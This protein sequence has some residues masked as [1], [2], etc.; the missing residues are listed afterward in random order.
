MK[1]HIKS[2]ILILTS[3]I[4]LASFVL[5]IFA[6]V[7]VETIVPPP[8]VSINSS[9]DLNISKSTSY[10]SNKTINI[11]QYLIEDKSASK[12][13][14]KGFKDIKNYDKHV[15]SA[16]D[17]LFD[18][19][20]SDPKNADWNAF[21]FELAFTALKI[22][23]S[24]CGA[25]EITS[26]IVDGI[27]SLGAS[28]SETEASLFL[29]EIKSEFSKIEEDI[30]LARE[31]ISELSQQTDEQTQQLISA[32]YVA[33]ESQAAQQ[34]LANFFSSTDGNFNYSQL[35]NYL[36]GSTN[37]ATNPKYTQAYANKLNESKA[38]AGSEAEKYYYDALFF[39]LMATDNGDSCVNMFFDSILPQ[40][41]AQKSIIYYYYEY[42]SANPDLLNGQSAEYLT[43]KFAKDLYETAYELNRALNYCYKY[44]ELYL[45]REYGNN[46]SGDCLY[47]YGDNSKTNVITYTDIMQ[48]LSFGLDTSLESLEKQ[49]VFDLSNI[50]SM[51]DSYTIQDGDSY[52]LVSN[53]NAST[54]GN[55]LS[56]QTVYLN[57]M[58]PALIT[59][60]DLDHTGFSY[61]FTTN[62]ALDKNIGP[63]YTVPSNLSNFL[64]TL[65]YKGTTL[66]TIAFDVNVVNSFAGGS[67]TK[68]DPYLISNANQLLMLFNNKEHLDK[69]FIIIKD[70]NLDGASINMLGDHNN[71]FRGSLDGN[72]H[73]ISN[74][75]ING[76]SNAALFYGIDFGATVQNLKIADAE[77]IVNNDCQSEQ[78]SHAAAITIINGGKIFNCHVSKSSVSV[79]Q[80]TTY[81]NKSISAYAG[82]I[83]SEN[84][85]TIDFSSVDEVNVSASSTRNYGTN[86]DDSNSSFCYAGGIAAFTD[87]YSSI[88]NCYTKVNVTSY[89]KSSGHG[90]LRTVTPTISV[91]SGGLVG[92]IIGNPKITNVF[93]D[94]TSSI[95]AEYK[96][97][98]TTYLAGWCSDD[99]CE[100]HKDKY[101]ASDIECTKASDKEA[102][103]YKADES[104]I[105]V[106]YSFS[107]NDGKTNTTFN[108]YEGLV[109]DH[110]EKLKLDDLILDVNGEKNVN[111]TI[112]S[113]IYD[114]KNSDKSNAKETIATLIVVA[115]ISTGPVVFDLDLPIVINKNVPVELIIDTLPSKYAYAQ[116]DSIDLTGGSFLLNYKD[117]SSVNVTRN[118]KIVSENPTENLGKNT[119]TVQFDGFSVSFDI[120]VFCKSYIN[121]G[122]HNLYTEEHT[123]VIEPN[124]TSM[125]YTVSKCSDCEYQ[126]TYKYTE[127]L[128]HNLS[129]ENYKDPTCTSTGYSGDQVC[130]R[131][132][133]T[134]EQGNELKFINHVYENTNNATAH[135]CSVCGT[136]EEHSFST[137]ENE[138]AM[139][140]T[141]V[142]CD[143]AFTE[144]KVLSDDTPRVVVSHAYALQDNNGLITVYVQMINNPGITGASFSVNYDERLE[145]VEYYA[146]DVLDSITSCKKH[147]DR[148]SFY[149]TMAK[150]QVEKRDGN[151]LKL[152]FRM[153]EHSVVLDEYDISISFSRSG[154]QF[155]DENN[156]PIDIITVDGGI[157]VVN[158][159]PGDVNDDNSVDIL[160][161]VL[162]AR[163][164]SA[165]D[166]EIFIKQH[167]DVDI[168]GDIDITDL[169]R[170]LQNL[171]GGFDSNTISPNFK[172][173][174][175]S[176]NG[177]SNLDSIIVS[178]F[179]E[180]GLRNKYGELPT[181]TRDGYKFEG[182]YTSFV[183]GE[184]ITENSHI[185]YNYNQ[186]SQTLYA[187]WTPNTIIF[188]GNGATNGQ[189]N[190]LTYSEDSSL[191]PLGNNFS[192][193]TTIFINSLVS[194]SMNSTKTVTQ[195]FLGWAL[196]P[197]S[198]VPDYKLGH[199]ID[200]KTGEFGVIT[201]YAVWSTET[202]DMPPLEKIGSEFMG[203]QIFGNSGTKFL[204]AVTTDDVNSGETVF[205]WWAA[206]K[207][208]I[209]YHGGEG[210]F[211]E[212]IDAPANGIRSIDSEAEALA[213]NQFY[214]P[215]FTFDCWTTQSDGGGE[216]FED[217]ERVSY[218]NTEVDGVVHL[219]AKWREHAYYVDFYAN[220][221]TS[222]VIRNKYLYT[223]EFTLTNSMF[224]KP[225]YHLS[226]WNTQPNGSGTKYAINDVLSELTTT[227]EGL[228]KTLY[229]QWTPNTYNITFNLNQGSVLVPINNF[230]H[231]KKTVTYDNNY[232]LPVPSCDFYIFEGWYNGNTKYTN[233]D[234]VCLNVYNVASDIK[235]TAKWSKNSY[236]NFISTAS[237]LANMNLSAHN[238]LIKD[239]DF[240]GAVFTPL[241]TLSG[242][243]D[244]YGHRI[245]NIKIS[246]NQYRTG[247]FQSCTGTIKN[248]TLDGGSVYAYN[249][250]ADTLVGGI[251][252]DVE[253]N[254]VVSN[255]H[256]R[257]MTIEGVSTETSDYDGES[258][259]AI[260]GGIASRCR[261]GT[262]TN[263]TVSYST[264]KGLSHKQDKGQSDGSEVSVASIGGV[265]GDLS[266]GSATHC[267][268]TGNTISAIAQYR[269]WWTW[270]AKTYARAYAGGV[271]GTKDANAYEVDLNYS[272]NSLSADFRLYNDGPGGT[273]TDGC[274]ETTGGYFGNPSKS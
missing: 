205:A 8:N 180:N 268:S 155:S 34:A 133:K 264:I 235:L 31:D 38:E 103:I 6:D 199:I 185:Y 30:L 144:S 251:V 261:G 189:M 170:L 204:T 100:S 128:G 40:S 37:A 119:V 13:S 187:R 179:D 110:N 120:E 245:I 213:K 265:I 164:L 211:G 157:T 217:G 18:D 151:I 195:S 2:I 159:L 169:T 206:V 56:G 163:Y 11:N 221:G 116:G 224:T 87:T 42:L 58:S 17:T 114:T 83:C 188:D 273:S 10:Y 253:A 130:T 82:G 126:L 137:I 243:F 59:L 266:S 88:T 123:K 186:P 274:A 64:A 86:K 174:L 239:I 89:A 25:G 259:Y 150:A 177:S 214:K 181:L 218:I 158:H 61:T 167:A 147:N 55:V 143:Y 80:N 77:F 94:D 63:A 7:I 15:A 125:G 207:Y 71:Y 19:V 115:N 145:L 257:Y 52:R 232:T 193:F 212:T 107:G 135:S 227:D 69:H 12:G 171:V 65:S 267:R 162:I 75:V 190:N 228:G 14:A 92:N 62:S 78:S 98:N 230:S 233:K 79:T 132:D 117:G 131:C 229:A 54:Y 250:R 201:L 161:A 256:V 32:L 44:Q 76:N 47:Y 91:Y 200:L 99:K 210:S 134:I 196:D 198:T 197:N 271:I 240:G 220:N 183:G 194:D 43:V 36:Y 146:A 102:T 41:E 262:V 27:Y 203:W 142:V 139:I 104:A 22:A 269:A 9:I 254:G 237:D 101:F 53:T 112:I 1:K 272:G 90:N 222:S 182:W 68:S 24:A 50:L 149:F 85:G 28:P 242:T 192:K 208:T 263:C 127:K 231:T 184:K 175:N 172:I 5:P 106:V 96:P 111:Y 81:A 45:Q 241:G 173:T 46:L 244:G 238:V 105:N 73:T 23:G 57:S 202:F 51:G 153:P 121:N 191:V 113:T 236:Y 216:S 20:L 168:D 178:C 48:G 33:L 3:L 70:I 26:T 176:N 165:Y 156:N 108:R 67:G 118:L 166:D 154:V 246:T 29:K 247:L 141:C 122:K 140:Y 4:L 124:C 16:L 97:E 270:T 152:I 225:G 39:A 21:G 226:S 160:D 136:L 49:I 72:N 93:V 109:Y 234:G 255:C 219:Y 74:F 138:E 84:N 209:I 248:L 249:D 260:V 215:G 258:R 95:S 66:F 35:K 60:F 252:A 129:I 223:K 148:N